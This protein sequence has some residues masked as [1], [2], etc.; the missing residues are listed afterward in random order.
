MW[1]RYVTR[2]DPI[3]LS[4]PSTLLFP[5]SGKM[6]ETNIAYGGFSQSTMWKQHINILHNL[7]APWTPFHCSDELA[8][9]SIVYAGFPHELQLLTRY[10]PHVQAGSNPQIWGFPN[11]NALIY[12][13]SNTR[14]LYWTRRES[15]WR[16]NTNAK[17]VA[18]T[19]ATTWRL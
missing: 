3:N 7:C 5:L 11:Y 9:T 12:L 2:Y 17:P 4:T 1:W 15:T 19:S 8:E 16:N 13:I 18:D 14:A 10:Q 6:T